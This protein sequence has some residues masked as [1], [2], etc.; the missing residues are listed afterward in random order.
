MSETANPDG[1]PPAE[2]VEAIPFGGVG[3]AIDFAKFSEEERLQSRIQDQTPKLKVAIKN[4]LST[5][6]AE[7]MTHS[8]GVSAQ[9]HPPNLTQLPAWVSTCRITCWE[10]GH[11]FKHVSAQVHPPNLTQLPAWVSTC[12]ITCWESGHPFKHAVRG[13]KPLILAAR[14][15]LN[16]GAASCSSWRG[17]RSRP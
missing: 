15:K 2:E 7:A 1:T 8:G 11:P 3:P 13:Q 5:R 10:S 16:S 6:M 12:R 4:Y 9:V 14:R 17:T